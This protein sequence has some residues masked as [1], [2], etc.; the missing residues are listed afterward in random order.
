M[1]Q[2]AFTSPWHSRWSK[3][4]SRQQGRGWLRCTSSPWRPRPHS[5]CE[6]GGPWCGGG[7][8]WCHGPRCTCSPSRQYERPGFPSPSWRTHGS[9]SR[10]QG[11]SPCWAWLE[12]QIMFFWG[13]ERNKKKVKKR[14]ENKNEWGWNLWWSGEWC[15]WVLNLNY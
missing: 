5:S 6:W 9:S 2:G 11:P 8:S 4:Q 14:S 13:K 3:S 15:F 10:Q 12:S 7:R 1:F